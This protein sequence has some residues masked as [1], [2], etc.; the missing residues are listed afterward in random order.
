MIASEIR[1]LEQFVAKNGKC[2]AEFTY[3]DLMNNE[4]P[5]VRISMVDDFDIWNHNRATLTTDLP[6][7]LRIIVAKGNEHKALE[8]L[9][10]LYQK[11]NQ[12]N[13]HKGNAFVG[14][15]TPSLEEETQTFEIALQYNLK[16]I[17]QDKE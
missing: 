16:L 10:R 9:E 1:N 14:T 5:F 7:E 17:I 3:R 4:Y 6:L 15:A 13:D 12:F 2:N 11:M 8:V